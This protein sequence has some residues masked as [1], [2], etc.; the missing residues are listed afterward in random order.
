MIDQLTDELDAEEKCKT[1]CAELELQV[2][3][4]PIMQKRSAS[5]EVIA[6]IVAFHSA[7]TYSAFLT[8][9]VPFLHFNATFI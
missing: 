2:W 6:G 1:R 4:V 5:G 8:K 7:D 3:V 9:P